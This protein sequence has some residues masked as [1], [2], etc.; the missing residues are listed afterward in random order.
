MES[1]D[2]INPI[3]LGGVFSVWRSL[4]RG[5]EAS[6]DRLIRLDDDKIYRA[7]WSTT[8]IKFD[9]IRSRH[10]GLMQ[11]RNLR[12]RRLSVNLTESHPLANIVVQLP[13][14]S[15]ER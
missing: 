13:L 9:L 1:H 14:L 10:L 12:R 4:Q 2:S 6:A 3:T 15:A 7:P 8:A 11:F 5:R